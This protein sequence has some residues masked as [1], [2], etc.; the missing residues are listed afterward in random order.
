M[1]Q[2]RPFVDDDSYELACKHPRHLEHID[3]LTLIASL[4]D[5][6][7]KTTTSGNK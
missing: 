6:H 5:S 4:N 2:K 7:P 1:I 3:Q